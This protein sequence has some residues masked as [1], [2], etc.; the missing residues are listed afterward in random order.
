[1]TLSELAEKV[2]FDL[3]IPKQ[4]AELVVRTT[5]ENIVQEV[6]KGGRVKLSRFGVFRARKLDR[7]DRAAFFKMAFRSSPWIRRRLETNMEKLGVQF[8]NTAAQLAKLSGVCPSCKQTLESKDPP[9][10]VSCGTAPFEPKTRDFSE[11]HEKRGG[12]NG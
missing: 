6:E 1:M 2:A 3:C 12:S 8:D 5:L 9:R 10:C 11:L 7:K 4:T